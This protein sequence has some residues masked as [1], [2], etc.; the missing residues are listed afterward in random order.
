MANGRNKSYKRLDTSRDPG[1]FVA[2]PW[3]VLDSQAF[4][5][6]SHPGKALLLELARQYVRGNNGRLLLSINHLRPRGWRSS[7]VINRAKLELIASGLIFETFK[8]YRPNKASWYALTWYS[9]DP[10]P[11]FDPGTIESFRRG[12]YRGSEGTSMPLHRSELS[13]P[14]PGLDSPDI[15]PSRGSTQ[16]ETSPSPGA[17]EPCFDTVS[18]LGDGNHLDKPSVRGHEGRAANEVQL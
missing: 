14:S 3:S 18:S 16:S 9:L 1:G 2:L 11:D 7:D 10:H 6:L 8:G 13:S 12:S 4:L 15:A 17:M 5:G